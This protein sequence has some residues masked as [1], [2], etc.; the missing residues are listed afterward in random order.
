MARCMARGMMYKKK[1]AHVARRR[2]AALHLFRMIKLH[3]E[4]SRH[5]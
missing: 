3:N 5:T 1:A 2:R 4:R